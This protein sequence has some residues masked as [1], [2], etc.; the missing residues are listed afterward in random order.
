MNDMTREQYIEKLIAIYKLKYK[1]SE[2]EI[3]EFRL[4]LDMIP[5]RQS[6]GITINPNDSSNKRI[7]KDLTPVAYGPVYPNIGDSNSITGQGSLEP[8]S[9]VCPVCGEMMMFQT[10]R[11][12]TSYPPMYG[13]VCPKCCHIE[14]SLEPNL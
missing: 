8:S 14:Y 4:M 2:V 7:W 6:I 13:Y 10:D 5:D 3:E 12:C 11:V 1:P 9:K